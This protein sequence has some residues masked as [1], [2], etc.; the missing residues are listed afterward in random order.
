MAILCITEAVCASPQQ[1]FVKRL[2]RV[3]LYFFNFAVKFLIY[4]YNP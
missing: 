3:F 4:G 2:Q 1:K